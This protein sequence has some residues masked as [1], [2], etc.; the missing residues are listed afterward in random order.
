[1]APEALQ[2]REYSEATDAYSFGVL[3]WCVRVIPRRVRQS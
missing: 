1:M 3:L 2:K